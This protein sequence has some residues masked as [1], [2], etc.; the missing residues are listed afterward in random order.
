[1]RGVGVAR[2]DDCVFM[3]PDDAGGWRV[4][5]KYHFEKWFKS[6]LSQMSVNPDLYF[7][8]AFRHG[9]IALALA[10]EQNVT[11]VKLQSNHISDCICLLYTSPSPRAS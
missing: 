3:I 9:S 1:M 2:A 8:H 5:V 6:R 11:L 7:L 4:M 10:V